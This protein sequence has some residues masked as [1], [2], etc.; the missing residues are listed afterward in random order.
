MIMIVDVETTALSPLEGRLTV[1]AGKTKDEDFAFCHKNE[2]IMLLDFFALLKRISPT[3]IY[4]FNFNFDVKW[5]LLR[6]LKH[7]IKPPFDLRSRS[8]DLRKILGCGEF[9]PKGKLNDYGLFLE[10]GEKL[11]TGCGAIKLW[12]EGNHGDLIAYCKQDVDLTYQL[13]SKMQEVGLV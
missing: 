2:K 4:G 3:R 11:D 13:H 5:I 10:I 6:A 9:Q 7:N 1:I 12:E 8:E